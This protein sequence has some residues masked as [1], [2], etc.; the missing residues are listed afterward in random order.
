MHSEHANDQDGTVLRRKLKRRQRCRCYQL[1]ATSAKMQM[2]LVKCY[3]ADQEDSGGHADAPYG[4][5]NKEGKD[6]DL[7][8]Y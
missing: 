2:L 7:I 6:E 4:A 5:A 3:I 8:I 1:S